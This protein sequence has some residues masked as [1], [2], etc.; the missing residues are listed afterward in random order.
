MTPRLARAAEY[1]TG[2]T[3][4]VGHDWLSRYKN[5]DVYRYGEKIYIRPRYPEYLPPAPDD[6]F[7]KVKAGDSWLL[8]ADNVYKDIRYHW[9]VTQ[10]TYIDAAKNGDDRAAMYRLFSDPTPGEYL[11]LPTRNRALMGIIA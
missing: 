10:T 6:I 8:V 3:D 9:I 11:R 4:T 2:T 7:Y 1:P 5:Y